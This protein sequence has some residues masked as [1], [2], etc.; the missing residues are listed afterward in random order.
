MS[1]QKISDRLY[2]NVWHILIKQNHK[3]AKIAEYIFFNKN[4]SHRIVAAGFL[5]HFFKYNILCPP[6][7]FVVVYL[8]LKDIYKYKDSAHNIYTTQ[9]HNLS[10]W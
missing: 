4:I 7:N 2:N 9:R 1:N 5:E 3:I 6:Q 8:T 10:I